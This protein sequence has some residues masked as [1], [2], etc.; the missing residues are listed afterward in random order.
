M[1]VHAICAALEQNEL[2]ELEQLGQRLQ[3]R[4]RDPV[5]TQE[6]I[7]GSC[8]NL[9]KGVVRLYKLLPDGRRQIVGFALPGDFL[10]ISVNGR[11]GISADA[12]GPVTVCRFA[13]KSF[14][15]FVDDR[16]NVLRRINEF[17][18]RDLSEAQEQ[19][20]L[21]GRRSAEEKIAIF[22]IKW[23]DRLARIGPIAA[24]TSVADEPAG[25]RRLSWSDHRNRQ[26]DLHQDGTR[27]GDRDRAGR[28]SPDRRPARGS[29]G[30]SVIAPRRCIL[31]GEF[32]IGIKDRYSSVR[33]TPWTKSKGGRYADRFDA[34]FC[35]CSER[36]S[37]SSPAC[38]LGA[39]ASPNQR[40]SRPTGRAEA[41]Q[42]L[43]CPP[44]W[45]PPVIAPPEAGRF[46][47][48]ASIMS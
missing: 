31:S 26:P 43:N 22:L 30:R 42:L 41:S 27:R 25:Y 16:P 11:H 12:V 29:F 14:S 36:C 20:V 21:L 37:W 33:H 13:R 7:A 6:D 47:G 44:P 19:M 40:G 17:V 38:W 15:R 23:R 10:G 46:G 34:G 1:R 48:G 28:H 4:P 32:L 45:E 39:S 18:A 24:V 5:F 2:R 8:Y 35:G 3:Y 9:L